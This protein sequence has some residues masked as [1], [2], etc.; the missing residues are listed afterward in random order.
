MEKRAAVLSD[1]HG[2]LRPEVFAK[3]AGCDAVAHG[4]DINHPG[5]L[6]RTVRHDAPTP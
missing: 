5:I 3:I 2:L 1:T 4:G 6:R